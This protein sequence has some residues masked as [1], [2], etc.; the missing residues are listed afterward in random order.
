LPDH[1]GALSPPETSCVCSSGGLHAR[2]DALAVVARGWYRRLISSLLD[3]CRCLGV[4]RGFG[5][6]TLGCL[7]AEAVA[8]VPQLAKC[9]Q[10]LFVE[11]IH[12]LVCLGTT[13]TVN[14]RLHLPERLDEALI[15]GELQVFQN[16]LDRAAES[17]K[18]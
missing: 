5:A 16:L 10:D 13:G 8:Q 2:H 11:F 17:E 15:S 3:I 4:G 6:E 14:K 18:Q 7:K 9:I 1:P 12:L